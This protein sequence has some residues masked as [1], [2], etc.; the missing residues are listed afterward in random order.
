MKCSY[1][2]F[3][4]NNSLLMAV[5]A[6]HHHTAFAKQIHRI[7]SDPKQ[8]PD[9]IAVELGHSLVAE[10][11]RYLRELQQGTSE[12]K[13]LP[14]MLGL[15][16]RNRYIHTY[17]AE[18]ALLLQDFH[19]SQLFNLP[20]DLLADRLNFSKWSTLFISPADSIIE[21]VRCAIELDIP[22]YGVDLSDFAHTKMDRYSIE[23]PQT[24]HTNMLEYWSRVMKY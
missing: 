15:M 3:T 10:L 21:A 22:L 8:R 20:D 1:H 17:Q 5:P 6:V 11:E 16:K 13:I 2:S 12:K 14:C 19:R 4:Y 9:A 24:A 7:C 18:K 23:D